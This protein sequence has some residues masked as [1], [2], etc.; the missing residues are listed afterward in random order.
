MI[1]VNRSDVWKIIEHYSPDRQILKSA[2]ECSELAQVCIKVGLGS[3]KKRDIDN[4]VEEIADVTLMLEQLKM[5]LDID[6]RVVEDIVYKKIARQLERM[7]G[8][9][10]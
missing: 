8:E 9:K 10:D 7:K 6:E 1:I 3:K 2:E 5:I 4:I